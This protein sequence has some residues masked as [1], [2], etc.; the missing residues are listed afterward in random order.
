MEHGEDQTEE[1]E[2]KHMQRGGRHC[3]RGYIDARVASYPRKQQRVGKGQDELLVR[4]GLDEAAKGSQVGK[5]D[6]DRD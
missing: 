4:C 1:K 5:R 3:N 6:R 2:I